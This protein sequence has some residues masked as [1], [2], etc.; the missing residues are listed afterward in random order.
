M[1]LKPE[2]IRVTRIGIGVPIGSELVH[3]DRT[4][5]AEALQHRSTL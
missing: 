1:L 4:T 5:M 2:G 3:A